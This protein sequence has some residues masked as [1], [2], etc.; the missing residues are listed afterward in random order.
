MGLVPL[1]IRKTNYPTDFF[2]WNLP[3]NPE[4]YGCDFRGHLRKENNHVEFRETQPPKV[5]TSP[6]RHP[7]HVFHT[8]TDEAHVFCTASTSNPVKRVS[9]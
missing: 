9:S 7:T 5:W 4:T 6:E 3:R 2:N 1:H 8:F